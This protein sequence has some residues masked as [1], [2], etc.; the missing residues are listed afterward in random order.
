MST[1]L[2]LCLARQAAAALRAALWEIG[3]GGSLE[4]EQ[5]AISCEGRRA[6]A[7]PHCRQEGARG[8][9]RGFRMAS[10][11]PVGGAGGGEG[12]HMGTCLGTGT[13]ALTLPLVD[14]A[15]QGA[16]KLNAHRLFSR[17]TEY[18][19]SPISRP[20]AL[21]VSSPTLAVLHLPILRAPA[22]FSPLA[23][24]ATQ[25]ALPSRFRSRITRITNNKKS[26]LSQ[27]FGLGSLLALGRSWGRRSQHHDSDTN[28]K[29]NSTYE[30]PP[31]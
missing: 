3:F 6:S 22:F 29:H 4:V 31:Q 13:A 25:T 20:P 19:S 2:C 26:R 24:P 16:S 9:G 7:V 5:S 10:P 15:P 23:N 17:I 14:V 30:H 21:V 18:G 27:R 12:Q 11:G 1:T 28:S 8:E